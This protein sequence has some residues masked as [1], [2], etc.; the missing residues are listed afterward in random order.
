MS[1]YRIEIKWA[2]I[3]AIILLIWVLIEQ[4]S[5]LR[6]TNLELQQN[7]SILIL[8]PTIIIYVLTIL[9]KKRHFYK[10][11]MSFVQGFLCG[12][13][14]TVCIMILTPV[15]QF[16]SSYLI[17]P[18]YFENLISFTV[19]KGEV[20]REMAEKQF[21]YGNFLFTNLVFEMITG[22]V[23]AAFIP[24]WTKSAKEST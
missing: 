16:I 14:L 3:H 7:I 1:Q 6:D 17:S 12:I 2:I 22:V 20:T 9:D 5:G 8:V 18:H 13:A 11:E 23:F 15:V 24:L 19:K 21:T 4:L 10:G